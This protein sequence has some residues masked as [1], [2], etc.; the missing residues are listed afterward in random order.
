MR[1]AT[2][3][4]RRV[5]LRRRHCGPAGPGPDTTITRGADRFVYVY[6]YGDGW[7][8]DVIFEE[9]RGGDPDSGYRGSGV[10]DCGH[11]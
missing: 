2:R 1:C 11:G 3:R 10:N 4:E 8:H 6:D 5:P 7:R 9:V